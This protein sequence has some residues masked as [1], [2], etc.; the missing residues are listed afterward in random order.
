[1]TIVELVPLAL[2]T[3]IIVMAFAVGLTAQPRDLIY[4][5]E[6]PLRLARS[7]TSMFLVMLLAAVAITRLLD[8]HRTVEIVIVCLALS[9]LPPLLPHKLKK[10]G[11]D[12]SYSVGLVVAASLF[13]L[14]WIPSALW[15]LGNLS[16]LSLHDTPSHLASVVILNILVPLA[17][18]ATIHHLAPNFADWIQVAFARTGGLLLLAALIPVLIKA[19]HP[20]LLQI[21]GGTVLTLV[22]FVVIGLISGHF[23]GG[24]DPDDRTVLALSSASR[25]PAIAVSLASINFPQEKDVVVVVLMYLII[26]AL[27]TLPYSAWRK[28]LEA[29]A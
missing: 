24:P 14:I 7:L 29:A 20:A 27:L 23:L 17:L 15:V 22:A 21:G 28:R 8:L 5:F 11:G 18:G 13:A 26:S 2:K 25:H 12:G 9:P 1:M 6:H 10:A 3:S 16:G 19:W 4:V